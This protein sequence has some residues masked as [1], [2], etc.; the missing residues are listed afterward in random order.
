MKLIMWYDAARKVV[1][2]GLCFRFLG[3]EHF[4]IAFC[5]SVWLLIF[6][7]GAQYVLR[8]HKPSQMHVHVF[9][10]TFAIHYPLKGTHDLNEAEL[11]PLQST[12]S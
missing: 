7:N 8:A 6:F 12:G 1:W 5:R 10:K 11:A 3:G 4:Y 9:L 2:L